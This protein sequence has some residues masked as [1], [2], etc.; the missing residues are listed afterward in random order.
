MDSDFSSFL[1]SLQHADSFFPSGT[2]AMSAGLEALCDE[3]VVSSSDSIER[4]VYGQLRWR[5]ATMD[6]PFVTNAAKARA[7]LDFLSAIDRQIEIQSLAKESREGSKRSGRALL[8]V[9]IK[10]GTDG[11]ERYQDRIS[12]GQAIG[13]NPVVQG[14][15]WTGVGIRQGQIELI[16]A[17]TFCVGILGAALRLGVIGHSAAQTILSKSHRVIVDVLDD[18]C[19]S[20]DEVNSF[21]PQQ[22]IALMRHEVM[23]SRLF[24]N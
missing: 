24:T 4:F 15:V 9:H 6:R 19:P 11:V 18:P 10:L 21:T 13:H 8:Q 7:D 17:H 12:L 14:L 23:T 20:L 5:W 1:R 2:V 22:E 16:S 3:G